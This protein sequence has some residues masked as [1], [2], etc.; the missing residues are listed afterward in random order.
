[1]Q[2]TVEAA[3]QALQ[4][5]PVSRFDV[6]RDTRNI[7][8]KLEVDKRGKLKGRKYVMF[9]EPFL[10]CALNNLAHTLGQE[11]DAYVHLISEERGILQK[12]Y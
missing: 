4:I 10:V 9:G 5:F 1:M 8:Q 2:G 11:H 3:H 12:A 6:W 7:L